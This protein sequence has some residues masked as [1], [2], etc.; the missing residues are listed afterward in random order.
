MM[1]TSVQEQQQLSLTDVQ[2]L[3]KRQGDEM[4]SRSGHI[5]AMRDAWEWHL[6]LVADLASM[7]PSRLLACLDEALKLRVEQS[8]ALS[9]SYEKGENVRRDGPEPFSKQEVP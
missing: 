6:C 7:S 3:L 4:L 8:V 9:T 5:H 1:Q 2:H